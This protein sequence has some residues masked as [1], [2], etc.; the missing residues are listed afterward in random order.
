VYD[1]A[2]AI[3]QIGQMMDPKYLK[4]PLGE[5]EKD[6]KKRLK[7]EEKKKKVSPYFRNLGSI[8]RL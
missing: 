7:E 2:C 8:L 5:D 1:L 4:D 6:K 3:L